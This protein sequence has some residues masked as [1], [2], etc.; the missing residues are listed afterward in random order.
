MERQQ[1]CQRLCGTVLL[2]AERYLSNRQWHRDL[3]HGSYVA[4]RVRRPSAESAKILIVII[5]S[6]PQRACSPTEIHG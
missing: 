6:L 2:N 4:I 1:H 3:S 5:I